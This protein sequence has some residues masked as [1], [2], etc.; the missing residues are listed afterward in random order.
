[1]PFNEPAFLQSFVGKHSRQMSTGQ[2]VLFG[3]LEF[4]STGICKTNFPSVAVIVYR[5]TRSPSN[6]KLQFKQG[7][8]D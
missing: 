6:L 7:T 1:M 8:S 2:Q 4:G 3:K 5:R